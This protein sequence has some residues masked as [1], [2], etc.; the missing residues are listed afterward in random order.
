MFFY[1]YA[2]ST[3]GIFMK[4]D[5]F[6]LPLETSHFLKLILLFLFLPSI[7]FCEPAFLQTYEN[8]HISTLRRLVNVENKIDGMSEEFRGKLNDRKQSY[9]V[10]FKGP[11]KILSEPTL[12]IAII[13][14]RKRLEKEE[15]FMGELK[16]NPFLAKQ[17]ERKIA[18][19]LL[20]LEATNILITFVEFLDEYNRGVKPFK[21]PPDI[22]VM[23]VLAGTH[24]ALTYSKATKEKMAL[25]DPEILKVAKADSPN[26]ILKLIES[27]LGKMNEDTL[28]L[29]P[30]NISKNEQKQLELKRLKK[31]KDLVSMIDSLA[32]AI[33]VANKSLGDEY[34][35]H[36]LVLNQKLKEQ[37]ELTSIQKKP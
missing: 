28:F 15:S 24:T 17:L 32:Q 12:T 35:Y 19:N 33:T 7:S 11:G 22:E 4:Y 21:G 29:I 3:E 23:K 8:L 34:Q 26:N 13:T 14:E 18:A 2:L 25:A 30:S 31:T 20:A 16:K 6:D 1:R 27:G 36:V 37:R 10:D 9:E 5:N